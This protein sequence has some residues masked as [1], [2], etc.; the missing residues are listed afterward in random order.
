[1]SSTA[2]PTVLT[3]DWPAPARVRAASTERAGGTSEGPYTSRN[4]GTH[5]GDGAAAVAANRRALV[6]RLKNDLRSR[7]LDRQH[8]RATGHPPGRI[9]HHDIDPVIL[10]EIA[11]CQSDASF[12]RNGSEQAA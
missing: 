6:E 4:L 8:G 3:P 2:P 5:V 10:I 12:P 7:E 1:M 9:G 11:G